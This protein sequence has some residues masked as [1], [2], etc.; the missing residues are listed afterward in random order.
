MHMLWYICHVLYYATACCLMMETLHGFTTSPSISMQVAGILGIFPRFFTFMY[1]PFDLR[2]TLY[3]G[4]D[5][6]LAW[7]VKTWSNMITRFHQIWPKGFTSGLGQNA[8]S[9]HVAFQVPQFWRQI[10]ELGWRNRDNIFLSP[11]SQH[12]L[13]WVHPVDDEHLYHRCIKD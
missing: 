9:S 7:T 4:L 10:F 6:G 1:I 13:D 8:R 11:N 3:L 2:L 5:W 12:E